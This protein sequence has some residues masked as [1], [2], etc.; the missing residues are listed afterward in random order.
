MRS[1]EYKTSINEFVKT[2]NVKIST[3]DDY[4]SNNNINHIDLLKIDFKL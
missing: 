2:T 4:F 3:L 1:N